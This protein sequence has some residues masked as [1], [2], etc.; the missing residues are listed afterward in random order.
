MGWLG[1][2][3]RASLD[4]DVNSILIA[5]EGKLEFMHPQATKKQPSKDNF[6]QRFKA[7]ARDHNTAMRVKSARK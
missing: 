2:T 6:A 4:T 5:M 7:F 1:W 3:E